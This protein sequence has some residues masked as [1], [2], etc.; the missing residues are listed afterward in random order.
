MNDMTNQ[1]RVMKPST[2]ICIVAGCNIPVGRNGAKDMCN[3]HYSKAL[4]AYK[5]TIA[6][7]KCACGCGKDVANNHT[8]LQGHWAKANADKI[9]AMKHK[10]SRVNHGDGYL[11]V[12][13]QGK[14]ILE[15]IAI[16]ENVIGKKLPVKAQVHHVNGDRSDNANANLVVCP[17]SAYH[18]LLHRRQRALDACGNANFRKCVHCK[19]WD[20]PKN[21]YLAPNA[22]Q[23]EHRACGNRYRKA[24]YK[25]QRFNNKQQLEQANA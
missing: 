6:T 21:L 13:I 9:S 24:F 3:A 22:A 11:S 14:N 23:S 10:H 8:F 1:K 15:H 2:R 18:Q 25:Q 17:N 20:D 12:S 19:Q 16:V 4:N 7:G 5:K